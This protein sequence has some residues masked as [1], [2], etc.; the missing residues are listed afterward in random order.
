VSAW[1]KCG[2]SRVRPLVGAIYSARAVAVPNAWRCRKGVRAADG[3]EEKA[4]KSP[5]LPE[6]NRAIKRERG[7]RAHAAQRGNAIT[8]HI[9]RQ[10]LF[11]RR[12]ASAGGVVQAA[13][14]AKAMPSCGEKAASAVRAACGAAYR[15]GGGRK[16]ERQAEWQVCARKRY[17]RHSS[18]AAQRQVSA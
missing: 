7:V 16:T 11:A 14:T 10:S 12:Q 2:T 5:R 6:G 13:R 9:K 8:A 1:L 15:S 4:R 3:A 17:K 18:H